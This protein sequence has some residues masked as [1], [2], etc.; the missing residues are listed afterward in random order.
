MIVIDPTEMSQRP[1]QFPAVIVSHDGVFHAMS[2]SRR[3][4]ISVATSMSKPSYS[5]RIGVQLRCGRICGVRRDREDALVL[6]RGQQVASACFVVA[7]SARGHAE[8][9]H[10][11]HPRGGRPEPLR[12]RL[13]LVLTPGLAVTVA[14][15]KHVGFAKWQSVLRVAGA[16]RHRAQATM[17]PASIQLCGTGRCVP[18]A[19]SSDTSDDLVPMDGSHPPPVPAA[20][21]LAA[22]R[23]SRVA[24][25]RSRAVGVPPRCTCPRTVTRVSKPVSCSISSATTRADAAESGVAVLDR[26]PARPG[27]PALPS[28]ES[29]GSPRRRRRSRSRARASWRRRM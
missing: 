4:A 28:G 11:H 6:D 25:R 10:E 21:E 24:R 22:L 2:T 15:P 9:E 14:A 18:I 23:P 29:A 7:P 17:R 3:L 20:R 8:C 16:R 13:L 12:H 26:A 1:F 27:L 5:P 19:S